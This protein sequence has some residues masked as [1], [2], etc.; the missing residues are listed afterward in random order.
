MIKSI[1]KYTVP[2]LSWITLSGTRD[3]AVGL[4]SSTL[5]LKMQQDPES[6]THQPRSM[7]R[8]SETMAWR[9]L[10]RKHS[11]VISPGEGLS[12]LGNGIC[13]GDPADILR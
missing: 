7:L 12:A 2:G 9:D 8:S 4:V 6:L 3:I 11:W 13:F 10:H 1:F 5:L